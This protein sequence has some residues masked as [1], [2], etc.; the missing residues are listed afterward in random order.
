MSLYSFNPLRKYPM[1]HGGVL[2]CK[3]R[4]AMWN[5]R[6]TPSPFTKGLYLLVVSPIHIVDETL[7]FSS[8][9]SLIH[10]S[11]PG[12]HPIF[13]HQ[14]LSTWTTLCGNTCGVLKSCCPSLACAGPSSCTRTA[15]HGQGTWDENLM[16]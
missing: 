11:V 15:C 3:I 4:Q 7:M 8:L 14:N 1:F 9:L 13:S 6:S 12:F 5:Q 16:T 2:P 10:P